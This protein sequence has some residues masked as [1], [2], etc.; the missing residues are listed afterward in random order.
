MLATV[1][2]AAALTLSQAERALY[3]K[4]PLNTLRDCGDGPLEIGVC[5]LPAALSA[6]D[7]QARLAGADL[8]WWR[9]GADQFVVVARR[10]TDQS[11]L[12]CAVRGRMEHIAG[13][14]WA[15]R[16]RIADLDSALLDISAEPAAPGATTGVWR[17]PKAPPRPEVADALQGKMFD[18]LLASKYLAAPRRLWIYTPPGFDPRKRYP[19][20]Y[21][22]DGAYRLDQARSIE[23]LILK[24]EL[25]PLL[26]VGIWQGSDPKFDLRG[27]EY[28][29]GSPDGMGF[30]LKHE[31]FLLKEVLPYVESRFGGSTD[32]KDRI[33]TGFSDGAAWAISMGLRHPDLF[34]SVIAQSFVWTPAAKGVEGALST[35]FYLSA[36]TLEPHFYRETLAFAGR[37]RAA[38]HEVVLEKTVSGH[39][40]P[41][42]NVLLLHGLKWAFA[43]RPTL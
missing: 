27:A 13:D 9:D 18:V 8:V 20:V 7:A 10:D 28:L 40:G 35:R 5:R 41:I 33:V 32:R 11:F 1:T 21:M 15:M 19:V 25:P 14:L 4:P 36:G 30:F 38:G 31:S 37:A 2:L 3:D 16:L 42:W 39:S 43:G 23:P 34:A 12:C 29:L 22:S 6:A 26:L 24:G 17:G